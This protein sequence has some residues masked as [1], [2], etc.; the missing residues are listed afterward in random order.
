MEA[1]Q[2]PQ[3]QKGPAAEQ[4]QGAWLSERLERGSYRIQT[5]CGKENMNEKDTLK[6]GSVVEYGGGW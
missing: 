6:M 5:E 1:E 4:G 3:D 2:W